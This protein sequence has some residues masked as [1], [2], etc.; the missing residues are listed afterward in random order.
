MQPIAKKSVLGKKT[1]DSAKSDAPSAVPEPQ[2][3]K[4]LPQKKTKQSSTVPVIEIAPTETTP[5]VADGDP[6]QDQTMD[7]F[8]IVKE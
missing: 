2:R 3:K 4:S 8:Y 7:A 1:K 5:T 6:K